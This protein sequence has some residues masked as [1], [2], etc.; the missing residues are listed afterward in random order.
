MKHISIFWED[1]RNSQ[2]VTPRLIVYMLDGLVVE[3]SSWD[4]L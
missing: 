4:T 2:N 3:T 1:T